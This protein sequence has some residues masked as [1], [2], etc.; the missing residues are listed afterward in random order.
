M[1]KLGKLACLL[2]GCMYLWLV[3]SLIALLV[4]ICVLVYR[5]FRLQFPLILKKITLKGLPKYA[6]RKSDGR[7]LEIRN[8]SHDYV[9]KSFGLL[10]C[11]CA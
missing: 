11:W 5:H 6:G 9:T 2:I 7:Q 10:G 4:D 8:P 3:D 1:S